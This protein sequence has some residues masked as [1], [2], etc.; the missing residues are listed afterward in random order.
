MLVKDMIERMVY[1]GSYTRILFTDEINPEGNSACLFESDNPEFV[2]TA[3]G[4]LTVQKWTVNDRGLFI[5]INPDINVYTKINYVVMERIKNLEREEVEQNNQDFLE[6]LNNI[7]DPSK[8]DNHDIRNLK[9]T[10]RTFNCLHRAGIQSIGDLRGFTADELLA[11]DRFGKHS[12]RE[13]QD[14]LNAYG[15]HLKE[16]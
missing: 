9:L 13:V 12:L 5:E 8:Y 11:I 6:S 14:E 15:L 10:R 16:D 2:K 4:N 1:A 7:P 3:F